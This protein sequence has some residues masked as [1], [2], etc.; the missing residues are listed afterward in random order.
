MK[1]IVTSL[2]LFSLS[3]NSFAQQYYD[4]LYRALNTSADD[5]SKVNI[6]YLLA[7]YFESTNPDSNYHYYQRTRALAEKLSYPK[8]KFLAEVALF[9][10]VNLHG[11]YV[12]ALGIALNNI[13]NAE[14]ITERQNRYYYMAY[15]Y[16]CVGIVK[17][18]MQDTIGLAE[19]EEMINNYK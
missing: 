13:S 11:N 12:R 2:L 3:V 4:S 19:S 16:Q 10:S 18:E 1:S 8:G 5:T 17:G 6:L 15:A 9:F 7:T 14:A